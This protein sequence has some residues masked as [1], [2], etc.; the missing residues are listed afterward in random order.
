MSHVPTRSYRVLPTESSGVYPRVFGRRGAV[1][2]E[3]T[4]SALAGIEIMQAG[5]NAIDAAVAA[6]FVEGVVNPQMHTIGGEC[7]ILVHAAG[8]GQVVCINGNMAAPGRAT[9][10][11][12]RA[13]G[14]STIPPEG[15]L[16][17]G[18][19]GAFGA[20]IEAL[21][22]FG[23][24]PLA[25]VIQPALTLARDG[26][27]VHAGMLK[28][29]GYGIA[30]LAEKFRAQ[31]PGSAA[32]YLPDGAV[33]HE[34][35]P[36]QNPALA[37]TF[38]Y[39]ANAE[40]HAGGAREDGLRAAFDAF[41]KGAVAAEIA[42]YSAA[43]DGLLDAADLARFSVPVESTVSLSFGGAVI[44]KCGPWNQGTA[45]LQALSILKRFDL[46]AMGHNSAE[47]LH[48]VIEAIKLAWADREQF[49]G[50]PDFVRIPLDAL[51]SDGY[52]AGRAALIAA[53]ASQVMRPGD[54]WRDGS[55]LPAG[56]RL[57]GAAWGPGTVHVDAMD[58]AGNACAATPSGAWIR[59][60]EVIP[61]LG[62][63]LG[64]R[65]SNCELIQGFPNVVAPGKRPRTTISPSLAMKDGAPWLAF[66]SMGGDQ[67]DQWQLQFYLNRTVFGMTL[68]QSIEA[69]KFSSEHFPAQFHPHEYVLNRV[70]IEPDV[71]AAALN[72]LRA[73]GHDL[74]VGPSWTEGFL[75]ATERNPETGMLEAGC[76]PRGVR[77]DIFPSCALAC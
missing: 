2:T 55:L 48:T 5:G 63:P 32:V 7:P 46:A 34:G 72:G 36:L 3:H 1:A 61:A 35:A 21:I 73:A 38:Q 49:Y 51:L 41:Y 8:T 33:P 31:W 67:Q 69:A 65:L 18:V 24:M 40:R 27:A 44:H 68:Q 12:F 56:E 42:A 16:A 64:T 60:A 6:T 58:A 9:P 10:E 30:A 57:G 47:Y 53:Q 14:L 13:R 19:P 43:H 45:F 20:L 26:F 50:D 15:I 52:G 54:P 75:C 25:D 22:R 17:A 71:G 28:Q 37:S 59:A 66:G 29:H 4:L 76:D 77:S 74:D 11:A 70:R 23:S 39:L 62:F